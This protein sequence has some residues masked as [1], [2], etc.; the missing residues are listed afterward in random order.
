[1]NR[2]SLAQRSPLIVSVVLLFLMI[3]I[4]GS[5]GVY[6]LSDPGVND[7][8][9]LMRVASVIDEVFEHDVAWDRLVDAGMRE[10]FSHLDPYSGYMDPRLWSRMNEEL[11]GSYTG[12]GVTVTS[13]EDGL[14][15][16]SVREDG[17]AAA[18]GML[19]GDVVVKID[20]LT[21]RGLDMSQATDILRGTEDTEVTLAVFRPVDEDTITVKVTRRKIDFVHIPF[22]GYTA[23]SAIYIRLLDFDAGAS[24]DLKAAVDSLL[25][26]PGYQPIGVIL[27]LRDNPGGLFTEAYQA[28]NLFLERDQFIVGTDGRSRWNEEQHW[29]SGPDITA[30][31]PMCVIVD[32]GSASSSEIFA[33][34]LRQLGRAILVGD[35]TFGKGLVQG[36][37][38]LHDGSALRLTVSRYY[39]ADSLYLNEFDSTLNEIGRGLAPDYPFR[40]LDQQPFP[41]ALERSLLLNQ[42]AAL[43]QEEIIARSDQF[44]LDDSWVNR[45][46]EYALAEGFEFRSATTQ[47]AEMLL[48]LAAM[49]NSGPAFRQLADNIEANSRQSDRDQFVAHSGYIKRRLEQIAVERRFGSYAAYLRA[50]VPSRPDIRYAAELLK[51][52]HE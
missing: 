11:S 17:P 51:S 20:T 23:D 27:D 30:G 6:V 38:L 43:H 37:S 28:A 10:M 33:G 7:A 9:E 13:H 34:S 19:S 3:L 18:A 32:R 39:L 15:I 29:S 31:L 22:A 36:F 4:G 16:M 41:R 48:E 44:G 12:I 40:F 5:A 49:E 1:M 25:S 21:L 26:R 2:P 14:L 45:F 47:R 52:A 35:T 8:I 50:V 24:R 46:K 42:F